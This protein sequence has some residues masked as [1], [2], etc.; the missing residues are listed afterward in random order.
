MVTAK[1]SIPLHLYILTLKYGT[2]TNIYKVGDN[3]L[4]VAEIG[5]AEQV[6]EALTY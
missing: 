4:V 6:P 3:K 5:A 1:H 2:C